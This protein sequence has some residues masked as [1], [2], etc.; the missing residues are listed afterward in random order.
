MDYY[1]HCRLGLLAL[2]RNADVPTAVELRLNGQSVGQYVS[3][4]IAAQTVVAGLTEHKRLNAL[5]EGEVPAS[6]GDW[7]Q[8]VAHYFEA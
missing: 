4:E 6:L 3:A 8:T 7:Q 2:V 5:P 1:C